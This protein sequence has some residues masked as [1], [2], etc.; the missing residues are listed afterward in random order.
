MNVVRAR[1]W[2]G[3]VRAPGDLTYIKNLKYKFLCI[4]NY[5]GATWRVF[6]Q[7]KEARPKPKTQNTN[8]YKSITIKNSIDYVNQYGFIFKKG[9]L[10]VFTQNKEDLYFIRTLRGAEYWKW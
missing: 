4:S 1:S 7:F 2:L 6:I 5:D 10:D 9:Q 8:W 3:I